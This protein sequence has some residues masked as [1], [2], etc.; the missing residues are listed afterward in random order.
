MYDF[1]IY[2]T[3]EYEYDNP[4]IPVVTCAYE[5]EFMLEPKGKEGSPHLLSLPQAALICCLCHTSE[6]IMRV[7]LLGKVV[8]LGEERYIISPSMGCVTLC[9]GTGKDFA[10]APARLSQRRGAGSS[11]ACPLCA[12]TAIPRPH[13]SS[14]WSTT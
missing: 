7:N 13:S 11:E 4:V 9:Q 14:L 5:E 2:Q 1:A 12:T 10:E 3:I 8:C 6:H